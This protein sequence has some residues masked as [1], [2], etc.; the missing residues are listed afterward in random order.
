MQLYRLRCECGAETSVS[1]GQAGGEVRCAGCGRAVAVPTLREFA[2]LPMAEGDTGHSGAPKQWTLRQGLIAGGTVIALVCWGLAA[3]ISSA[4][5]FEF[6]IERV[7]FEIDRAPFMR[8]Y[9]AWKELQVADVERD[10][11]IGE[12][13]SRNLGRVGK[14]SATTL[15]ALGGVGV[16]IALGGALLVRGGSRE[17][18]DR[19]A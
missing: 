9:A 7:Q 12:Y 16:L 2:Q 8:V 4:T 5:H 10:E 6:D 11:T 15:T 13:R 19:A 17:P 18:Q 3:W 14:A 1:K